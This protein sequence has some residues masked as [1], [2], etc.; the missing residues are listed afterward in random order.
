MK[1]KVTEQTTLI[2]YE[3]AC[4][5]P[6]GWDVVNFFCE[7]VFTYDEQKNKFGI[8]MNIPR[9]NDR[10]LVFKYYLLKTAQ[11]RNADF[12]AILDLDND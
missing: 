12:G 6:I 5:N 11:S 7:R 4:M 9:T 10:R 3:Y 8:D 1:N 2:D